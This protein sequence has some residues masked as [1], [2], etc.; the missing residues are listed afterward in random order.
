MSQDPNVFEEEDDEGP[1]QGWLVTFS[2]LLSLLLCFF[3]VL[4]SVADFDPIK[5]KQIQSNMINAF[6]VQREI[7][8]EDIPKGT[9]V[10]ATHF[11]PGIPEETPVETI[12]QITREQE[13]DSLR[14]GEPDAE[15]ERERDMREAVETLDEMMQLVRDTE[16]DADMLRKLLRAEIEAGQ[17]DVESEE[18]TILIRIREKGSF[19]SG[20]AYLNN[21]F[22]KVIDKIGSAIG[23]I[24]GRVFV[25][26]HTDSIPINSFAYPSNWDLAVSRAASVTRRLVRPETGINPRRITA[27]GFAATRPQ[28]INITAEGRARNRRVEI[29]IKQP[30]DRFE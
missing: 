14:L 26:G 1:D 30:I 11:Q 17:I 2:D 28:A 16:I 3:V 15:R 27:S 5:Y 8:L 25:E 20:S 23:Q 19:T 10:V 29:I 21:D 18:R 7:P 4:L 24:E 22:V 6:G 9:S 13:R 12:Q